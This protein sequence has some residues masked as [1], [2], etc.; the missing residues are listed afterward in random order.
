MAKKYSLI[1]KSDPGPTV[2]RT[3]TTKTYTPDDVRTGAKEYGKESST[4]PTPE[5]IRKAQSEGKQIVKKDG[6]PF[7]A[8]RVEYEHEYK[9]NTPISKPDVKALK[10]NSTTTPKATPIKRAAPAQQFGKAPAR[11]MPRVE[12]LRNKDSV[13]KFE[14]K[15]PKKQSGY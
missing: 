11:K 3:K 14:K 10:L 9:M 1:K 8:G 12:Y 6:L 13:T 15:R 4:K 7:R 5:F 2:V